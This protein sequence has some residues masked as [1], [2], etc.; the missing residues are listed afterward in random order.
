MLNNLTWKCEICGKERPDNKISV[1]TYKL[2]NF[3]K[4]ERNL[5]YC[6]DN[7]DCQKEAVETAETGEFGN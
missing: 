2:K 3:P 6:N 5:K 4:A 7:P 1:I